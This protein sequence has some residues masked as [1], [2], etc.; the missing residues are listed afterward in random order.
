[1]QISDA[2]NDLLMNL[3]S[4]QEIQKYLDV[5]CKPNKVVNIFTAYYVSQKQEKE[6]PA[7]LILNDIEL[8]NQYINNFNEL[9]LTLENIGFINNYNDLD[10][11]IQLHPFCA[12]L[13][14]NYD[15]KFAGGAYGTS[16][17]T[18]KGKEIINILESNNIIIDVAH[19]N[20]KSFLEFCDIT[21]FPIFCSHTSSRI[22]YDIPRGLD[23][24]QMNLIKESNGYIGL[25][26]YSSLLSDEKVT[27]KII[28]KHLDSFVNYT[29]TKN[30][31]FGTDFNATGECNPA[32]FD[33]DYNGI[34]NL[35]YKIS[36][37]YGKNSGYDIASLNLENY[38]KRINLNIK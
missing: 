22:I 23:I 36:K 10:R 4:I 27:E 11:L 32:G 29:S 15:N 9:T 6:M 30:V 37:K 5:Y 35:L 26:L 18:K 31:G 2:H 28:L 38:I 19:L 14:W 17:I 25:C 1:M 8:K 20:K 33:I 16:G 7:K 13:T 34:N 12:T 3:K 21:K 24:E